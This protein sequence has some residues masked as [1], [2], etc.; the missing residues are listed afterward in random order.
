M[1]GSLTLNVS[2]A[3]S[4]LSFENTIQ[5]GY[6]TEKLL[7]TMSIPVLPVYY[8]DPIVPNITLTPSF[9]KVRDFATPYKLAEYLLY[10]DANPDEYNKYHAWRKMKAPF[11]KK[12]LKF[13]SEKI[14]GP[15]EVE[16]YAGLLLRDSGSELNL[17]FAQR[18]AQCCRLCD[19]DYLKSLKAERMKPVP[20]AWDADHINTKF[21]AGKM[22]D[23]RS[24]EGYN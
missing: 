1:Y 3:I 22:Y 8:G 2:L 15:L 6:V 16:P 7:E 18:R 20:E 13:M 17:Q 4:Y 10:L 19:E 9:I 23:I 5:D 11:D 12:F 14:A 24:R 21:F